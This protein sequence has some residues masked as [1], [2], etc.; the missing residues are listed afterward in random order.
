MYVVCMF[1]AVMHS[2][3]RAIEV[4]ANRDEDDE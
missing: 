2:R 1:F 4:A 3:Q